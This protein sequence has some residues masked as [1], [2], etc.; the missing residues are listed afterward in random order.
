M[1]SWISPVSDAPTNL[2]PWNWNPAATFQTAFNNAREE[3]RAQQEFQLGMELE[4]ILLPAKIA[5]ADYDTKKFQMDAQVLERIYR[6]QTA[7]LDQSYSGIKSAIGGGGSRSTG[8]GSNA[9]GNGVQGNV[10]Q[11][12]ANPYGFGLGNIATPKARQPAAPKK[13]SWKVVAPAPAQG[14]QGP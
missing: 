11:Q 14:T 13:V 10:Q 2:P 9:A 1:A 5:K 6:N 4:K 8:S 7:A 12:Q 3:Q